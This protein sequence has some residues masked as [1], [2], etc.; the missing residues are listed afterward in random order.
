MKKADVVR[1]FSDDKKKISAAKQIIVASMSGKKSHAEWLLD[2][3]GDLLPPE[4]MTELKPIVMTGIKHGISPVIRSV[5]SWPAMI[6]K[7]LAKSR[8]P[9]KPG[10]VFDFS[11]VA[12]A[13]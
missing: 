13:D 9:K 8:N 6:I 7:S 1:G 10:P 5:F 12:S 4:W 11:H 2:Q 3:Y